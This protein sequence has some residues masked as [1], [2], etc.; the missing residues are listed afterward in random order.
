MSEAYLVDTETTSVERA[1]VIELA[2]IPLD[3]TNLTTAVPLPFLQRY[4]PQGEIEYGAMAVHHIIPDDLLG[5][6]PSIQAPAD[7]PSMSYM[8]GHNI[9]FD[10]RVLKQPSVKRICTLALARAVWPKLSSHNLS[11]LIYTFTQDKA[12]A[13]EALRNAH[14]ALADANNNIF[15]LSLLVKELGVESWEEL[16]EESERARIPTVMPFGKH[17]GE[18]IAQ[19]PRP[20]VLWYMKQPDTDPYIILAFRKAGLIK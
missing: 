10:W 20:Y 7:L 11:A 19:V 8:V 3:L 2:A 4:A 17:R 16:W 12:A 13:R 18:P 15:I 9:D 5:M 6:P 1:E 14:S